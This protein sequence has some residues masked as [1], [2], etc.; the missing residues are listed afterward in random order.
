MEAAIAMAIGFGVLMPLI[1]GHYSLQEKKIKLQRE[2]AMSGG[3]DM[4]RELA[5]MRALVEHMSDR[6]AVMERIVTDDDRRVA[7]EIDGLGKQAHPGA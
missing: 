2:L 7:R 4:Q 6:M 5:A 1:I 3:A